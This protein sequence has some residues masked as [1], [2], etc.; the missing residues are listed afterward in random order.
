MGRG[1]RNRYGN[2]ITTSPSDQWEWQVHLI[3][4]KLRGGTREEGGGRE[5]KVDKCTL[6]THTH[7]HTHYPTLPL[8]CLSIFPSLTANNASHGHSLESNRLS[9]LDLRNSPGLTM[10]RSPILVA[11]SWCSN[12]SQAVM[13]VGTTM[14][15]NASSFFLLKNTTKTCSH[16]VCVYVCVCVGGG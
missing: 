4:G 3:R 13:E 10:P 14:H 7:T 12:T 5:G 2:R 15:S 1:R 8:L 11:M 9:S 16:S 6:H